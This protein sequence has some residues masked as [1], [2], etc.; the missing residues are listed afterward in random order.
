MTNVVYTDDYHLSRYKNYR[1][2]FNE[3]YPSEQYIFNQINFDVNDSVL[4]IGCAT[5]G[6]GRILNQQYN[7]D[8]YVGVEICT[9]MVSYA[10]ETYNQKIINID[11]L[12][13]NVSESEKFDKVISLSCIDWNI[14]YDLM[15]NHAFNLVKDNGW[16]ILT[17]RFT[18]EKSLKDVNV[19]YTNA[20][21]DKAQ[22]TVI[23][24]VEFMN[25]V[26]S[27]PIKQTIIK[28]DWGNIKNNT[29]CPYDKLCFS[30]IG[31]Q[32]GVSSNCKY[33]LDLPKELNF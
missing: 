32:K 2:T 8:N 17:L 12:D 28:G 27:Q 19:A 31:L 23:N 6:L 13:Y 5:G 22:Y 15:L 30:A 29:V 1:Q 3:L 11:I 7:I 14:D 24:F 16:L 10:N 20:G 33:D 18:N 21:S 9:N 26:Q 25:W 4:D